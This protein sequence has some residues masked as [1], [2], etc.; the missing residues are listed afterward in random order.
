LVNHFFILYFTSDYDFYVLKPSCK[1]SAAV[2][3]VGT[4]WSPFKMLGFPA[5]CGVLVLKRLAPRHGA[6]L[7]QFLPLKTAVEVPSD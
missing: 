2:M 7:T 1:P 5:G 4:E 6:G 3:F